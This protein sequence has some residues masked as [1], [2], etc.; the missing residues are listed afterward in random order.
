MRAVFGMYRAR[1]AKALLPAK[2]PERESTGSNSLRR[3]SLFIETRSSLRSGRQ[4]T[5]YT[6]ATAAPMLEPAMKSIGMSM[7][8]RASRIEMW[9]MPRAPPLPRT[10]PI[11]GRAFRGVIRAGMG[12]HCIKLL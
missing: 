1:K 4:P 7:A 10:R 5:A 12:A 2:R 11:F 6:P 9:T 8:A 3:F